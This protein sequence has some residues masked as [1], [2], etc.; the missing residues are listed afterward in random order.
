[1]RF[2]RFIWLKVNLFLTVVHSYMLRD[3]EDGKLVNIGKNWNGVKSGK[4]ISKILLFYDIR[5][6][7]TFPRF[8]TFLVLNSSKSREKS[9]AHKLFKQNAINIASQKWLVV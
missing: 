6:L 8:V 1:M 2:M 3:L 7:M 4:T 5:P 9:V